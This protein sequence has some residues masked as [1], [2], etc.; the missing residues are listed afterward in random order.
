[1]ACESVPKRVKHLAVC[2]LVHS[3]KEPCSN[4]THFVRQ[5]IPQFIFRIINEIAIKKPY[6]HR[7]GPCCSSES[8]TDGAPSRY[9]QAAAL[10]QHEH[11]FL[12]TNTYS[13]TMAFPA[14]LCSVLLHSSLSDSGNRSSKTMRLNSAY[15]CKA[16]DTLR[17]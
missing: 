3:V 17:C 6:I 8:C 14:V 10:K 9:P 7:Q 11:L 13:W 2:R 5:R 15:S 4:M 1:M 16:S 12:I